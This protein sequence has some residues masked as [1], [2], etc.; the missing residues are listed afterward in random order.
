MVDL[1]TTELDEDVDE[2][3]YKAEIPFLKEQVAQLV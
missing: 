2:I 3:F 1:T